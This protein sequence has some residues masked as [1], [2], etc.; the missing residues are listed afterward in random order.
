MADLDDVVNSSRNV[1]RDDVS[2]DYFAARVYLQLRGCTIGEYLNL[3][4]CRITA[5]FA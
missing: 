5:R 1:K 4:A 2:F 3:R